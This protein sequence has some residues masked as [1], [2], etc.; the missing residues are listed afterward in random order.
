VGLFGLEVGETKTLHQQTGDPNEVIFVHVDTKQLDYLLELVA[1]NNTIIP[2]RHPK[3]TAQ[4]WIA[5]HK[6]TK[7]MCRNFRTIVYTLDPLNPHYLPIDSPD[8]QKYLD[9]INEDMDLDLKT[10]WEPTGKRLG[11]DKLRHYDC[12]ADPQTLKLCEEIKPFLD[13]FYDT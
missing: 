8:R 9:K 11:N 4:S 10:D 3:V 12:P 6:C 5:R 1:S 2:L 7:Q 13:R